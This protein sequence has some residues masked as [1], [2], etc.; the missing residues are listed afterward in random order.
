MLKKLNKLTFIFIM[1]VV[2]TLSITVVQASTDDYKGAASSS[3]SE[4]EQIVD[5]E[6]TV[7]DESS[8]ESS[9]DSSSE[10]SDSSE[11][12]SSEDSSSEDESSQE[13][14]SELDS[15]ASEDDESEPVSS[16][17]TVDE[18]PVLKTLSD[19]ASGG[20][21]RSTAVRAAAK[22]VVQPVGFP[23][24]GDSNFNWIKDKGYLWN[25]G[26]VYLMNGWTMPAAAACEVF[27]VAGYGGNDY[28]GNV[29]HCI[30]PGVPL[31][32]SESLTIE[33]NETNGANHWNKLAALQKNGAKLSGDEMKT[34]IGRILR[35][36][37]CGKV[38]VDWVSTS[39]FGNGNLASILATRLLIWETVVGERKSDFSHVSPTSNKSPVTAVLNK[40]FLWNNDPYLADIKTTI[41]AKYSEIEEAVQNHTKIPSFV[42]RNEDSATVH[43]LTYD[44]NTNK[45]TCTLTDSNNLLSKYDFSAS[46]LDIKKNGN[47]ITVSTKDSTPITSTATVTADNPNSKRQS[48]LVL[49]DD[50]VTQTISRGKFNPGDIQDLV[51][52][53]DAISD[54]MKGYVKF[55][56][57]Y[58]SAKLSKVDAATNS[59]LPGAEFTVYKDGEATNFKGTT[60]ASGVC[61][62][63][64]LPVGAYTIKETKAPSHYLLDETEYTFTISN[65]T[66]TNINGG[67]PIQN[68]PLGSIQLTKV[69]ASDHSKKLTGAQFDVYK[70]GNTT[71]PVG[72]MK[73]EDNDGVYTLGDLELGIYSIKE[74]K[75]P[76]GYRQMEDITVE[77]TAAGQIAIA[78]NDVTDNTV[79]NTPLGSIQLTKKDEETGNVLTGAGFTVYKNT[80]EDDE[81]DGNEIVGEMKYEDG[82]YSLGDLEL[83]TYSIKETVVPAGYQE[84]AIPDVEITE[85]GQTVI[86]YNNN[87]TTDAEKAVVNRPIGSV[88]L[89][90]VDE[91][92]KE[93]LSGAE[94][95]VYAHNDDG[96]G[97]YDDGECGEAVSTL[98]HK[99]GIMTDNEDGSYKLE[100]LPYGKYLVKETKAPTVEINDGEKVPTHILPKEDIYYPFSITKAGEEATVNGGAAIENSPILGS[101]KL[102]K[103][104][105]SNYETKLSGAVFTVYADTSKDGKYTETDTSVGTMQEGEGDNAGVYTLGDLPVGT[106]FV[107]E[108]TAPEQYVRN[109]G[110]RTVY[111]KDKEEIIL[112]FPEEGT[113][114]VTNSKI[115]G[116]VELTKVSSKNAQEYLS[117]AEFTVYTD[118]NE[119]GM[120]DGT[121]ENDEKMTSNG[122]MEY[123][124][125]DNKYKMTGIPSGHYLVVETRA[126]EGYLLEEKVYPFEIK[127]AYDD[128]V[129]IIREQI[130]GDPS[131]AGIIDPITNT[132]VGSVSLSKVDAGI[133]DEDPQ[134]NTAL[135]G[136]EFTVYA[137]NDDDDGIYEDGECGEAVSTLSH[138]DGKMT[139][140]GDG[141][142]KLENLL[143]GKY[144]VK[145]T[146]A[147]TV[148]I[149]MNGNGTIE[150]GEIV[151]THIL[152]ETYYP[153]EVNT[154]DQ[155]IQIDGD[156]STTTIIDPIPNTPVKGSVQLTKVAAD[157]LEKGENLSGATFVVYADSNGD[158]TLDADESNAEPVGTM[159][160]G[161]GENEGVYTLGNLRVGTYTYFVKETEAPTGYILDE[162]AYK[163]T[164]TQGETAEIITNNEDGTFENKAKNWAI[165]IVKKDA[166]NGNYITVAGATFQIFA[167]DDESNKEPIELDE[168]I[169]FVT[170]ETGTISTKETLPYGK[171]YKLI[172]TK[173]PYGYVLDKTPVEFDVTDEVANENFQNGLILVEKEDA[174][175]K[176]KIQI[177]KT[178]EVA[179]SLEGDAE[180]GYTVKYEDAGL[181]GAK[182]N[183]IAA[184]DILSPDG[185]G[186]IVHESGY[187]VATIITNEAGIATTEDLPLGKYKVQEVEAP[188]GYMVIENTIDANIEYAT[189]AAE[190]ETVNLEVKNT[191]RKFEINFSKML[192]KDE[193]G[194]IEADLTQV[195]FGLYTNGDLTVGATTLE[196]DTLLEKITIGEDG[197]AQCQSDL[198]A[199]SYYLKEIA[200]QEGYILSEEKY[201]FTLSYDDNKTETIN[202][203]VGDKEADEDK[204]ITNNL[205]KGSVSLSKVDA[206][207]KDAEGKPVALSGAEFTVYEDAGTEGSF[208]KADKIVATMDEMKNEEGQGTGSYKLE[209]LPY[210]KYLVKE[211]K[212][213]TIMIDGQEVATH[214]LGQEYPFSIT[215]D[216]Q[217][218]GIDGNPETTTTIDPIP[219]VPLKGS[220]KLTKVDEDFINKKLPG[221]AFMIYKDE[222]MNKEYDPSIDTEIGEM[223]DNEGVYTIENLRYGYYLLKE[224][225]AP[226][227]YK[228]DPD[229]YSFTIQQEK[230]TLVGNAGESY[231][232]KFLEEPE[233]GIFKLIKTDMSDGGLLEGVGFRIRNSEGEVVYEG[234]TDKYGEIETPLRYGKYTYQE[235]KAKEGYEL[236]ENE[237]SFEIKENGEVI[238]AE[239]QNKKA[240]EVTTKGTGQSDGVYVFVL[241]ATVSL[242]AGTT[243]RK[244]QRSRR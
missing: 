93:A 134:K 205:I 201:E 94:F 100:N 136:A 236:D 108:T 92:T 113:R 179:S 210:G 180:N 152:D 28:N 242:L 170:D 163:F 197:T 244:R 59:P 73:D 238:K 95:T 112:E 196:A 54:P 114:V 142:Y 187:N 122:T 12:S 126:P 202:I 151:S 203:T 64:N 97:I 24:N 209:N 178:G 174:R 165:K 239:M 130:D 51:T 27:T 229:Y 58:G 191:R 60:N 110:V 117:D 68:T 168:K 237:Y 111:V 26:D 225:Q 85:A 147:P 164:I 207:L 175:Q 55:K 220:A 84:I 37:Y 156:P 5:D 177:T 18:L 47:T 181:A 104:D 208:D 11:D 133:N 125:S 144:L 189:D 199:G 23:R 42:N 215:K 83:G 241:L 72:T 182:F 79:T 221:S 22:G 7:E 98:S 66:V 39:D 107:E 173:A 169:E 29:F 86:A 154:P 41:S 76:E 161:T 13:S 62:I 218:V 61:T 186:T 118:L 10:D 127:K 6:T 17:V 190:A 65:G 232:G 115:Y 53:G 32:A 217:I 140:N 15:E 116:S 212:A 194:L 153:F 106:Y 231:E 233:K 63:D 89:S 234:Y 228:V 99:D 146:K 123:D 36:S 192:E 172:E 162:N 88:S 224:I 166:L 167:P 135:S 9:S 131:T 149:D 90:K 3:I 193:Y 75:V 80:D 198:P 77:I 129:V 214:I 43:T 2:F 159:Q 25:R 16:Q 240:P 71:S 48:T 33:R 230:Q 34:V 219:N 67:N 183:V 44:F 227:G 1:A 8:Q 171:G 188:V 141:S 157:G 216:G 14:E 185:R 184:E 119:N 46:N 158:G 132:P 40:T 204:D 4:T 69:D 52:F 235:F 96:D 82:V 45:W 160:E 222:D 103:V 70:E 121:G 50:K 139:D 87:A 74:T 78:C 102:T 176:G 35:Y 124:K 21:L 105:A 120:L 128:E 211:T 56:A 101:M 200:T 31:Y 81:I 226:V 137:H 109:L 91:E 195:K 155:E 20:M 145:E 38:S 148:E 223:K 30:Q 213:P 19:I 206:E 243:L 57:E 143:Y 138:T 49:T 150:E